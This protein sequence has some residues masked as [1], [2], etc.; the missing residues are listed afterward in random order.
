MERVDPGCTVR[1]RDPDAGVNE[2]VEREVQ[3]ADR[4]VAS[5]LAATVRA[6]LVEHWHSLGGQLP[7]PL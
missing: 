6:E 4:D 7:E 2:S 5:L 1:Q 3:R